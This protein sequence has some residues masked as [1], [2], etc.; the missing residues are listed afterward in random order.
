MGSEAHGAVKIDGVGL[1]K[2]RKLYDI[3]GW[4]LRDLVMIVKMEP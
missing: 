1:G 2:L 4:Q 3:G